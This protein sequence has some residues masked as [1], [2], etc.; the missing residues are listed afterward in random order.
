MLRKKFID[1]I[2]FLKSFLKEKYSVSS[3]ENIKGIQFTSRE[4]DVMAC[5]LVIRSNKAIA[6]CL[7][8]EEKTVEHYM[9]VL[10]G[11]INCNSREGIVKFI[12]KSRKFFLFRQHFQQLL[13][14]NPDYHFSMTEVTPEK[15]FLG[16]FRLKTLVILC[17]CLIGLSTLIFINKTYMD[18][19][20]TI[21]SDLLIPTETAFLKRP[22]LVTQ[23]EKKFNGS[24]GIQTV[25]LVGIVGMGGVGKTTLARYFGRSQKSSVV[26]EINA[27]TK[28][29][30][31]NSFKDL[32]YALAQTKD[33]KEELDFIQR[34]QDPAE[35]GKQILAYVKLR[36]KEK[37]PWF[38]IYDNVE[39][40]ADI[41]SYFPHDPEVWGTG[42][43]IMTTRD[44]NIKNTAFMNPENVIQIEE[45]ETSEALR[46]FSKI[47]YEREPEKLAPEERRK[48]IQFLEIIPRFPLDVSVA[49]YYIKNTQLTYEQYLERIAHSSQTFESAQKTLLKETSNYTK[50]R[51]G[52]I[53]SSLEKFIQT[54]PEFKEL[55]L[56]ICLLDSQNIPKELL[57]FYDGTSNID[58]FL[59]HLKKYS[60][61]TSESQNTFSLH[62][63]TQALGQAFLL[64][65]LGEADKA[66]VMGKIIKTTQSFY[67]KNIKKKAGNIILLIPHLESLIKNLNGMNLQEAQKE[68][69]ERDLS[70]IIGYAH[71][72]C[73][74]NFKLAKAYLTHVY[75]TNT[76]HPLPNKVLAMLLKDLGNISAFSTAYD[77]SL[78][79]CQE[80]IKMLEK[81]PDSEILIA[82]NLK[83]M[84]VAYQHK[85]NFKEAKHCLESALVKIST[86]EPKLKIVIESEIYK[87]LSYIY[88]IT[89]I[90]KPEAHKAIKY[91]L[92]A[93]EILN[94]STFFSMN[95]QN[96][97]KEISCKVLGC[98][99][100]LGRI[101]GRLSNYDRALEQFKETEYLTNHSP[102]RCSYGL[103]R[104]SVLFGMGEVL[105]RKGQ[106]REAENNFTESIHMSQKLVGTLD[107]LRA[108]IFRAEARIRLN[109]LN[110]AYNDCAFVLKV[111]QRR[112]NNYHNLLYSTCLYH[113]AIIKYKQGDMEKS[114]EHFGDFFKGIRDFCQSFLDEKEFKELGD[115][116]AFVDDSVS[117]ADCLQRSTV[118]FS[119]IYGPTHPFV[120]DYVSENGRRL[121][122]G[123]TH[124]S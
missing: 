56:F 15:S 79:Y 91:C 85:N 122:I 22:N 25:A 1:F 83:S 2:Q 95:P 90:N 33:Q 28:D 73:S 88:S 27:E 124:L 116:K 64:G 9:R 32:A 77:E 84:A 29:S 69:Y 112:K 48:T 43:V 75:N 37:G 46:L 113:A 82:Q 36:L 54:N 55:L 67:E 11:K 62:R 21:R 35:K 14:N 93:L 119:V 102:T 78:V 100:M 41:K 53:T 114:L 105:L 74:R 19:S 58:Q 49:A 20:Q 39:T 61:T 118:V 104:D 8:I 26:W 16:N 31:I 24:Q 123:N 66:K 7:K 68:I 12:E 81:I 108:K 23:I 103:E 76:R 107:T 94:A 63:S 65:L 120:R 40:L 121:D 59:Y 42:K 117:V 44:S 89:Y 101:Y 4:I 72:K 6:S 71:K 111:G 60:L 17:G 87:F 106:L 13:A 97:P 47:L 10:R 3:L 18:T 109:N 115:K 92:K 34:I 51:Y 52:I 5:L 50:T 45:L 57:G 70:H 38:L 96:P 99:A 98:R 86:I 110:E 30:L 80:S